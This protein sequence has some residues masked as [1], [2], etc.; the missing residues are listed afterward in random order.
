ML[1]PTLLFVLV[2]ALPLLGFYFYIALR[3]KNKN[4]M[5]G[6]IVIALLFVFAAIIAYYVNRGK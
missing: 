2:F 4:R 6:L 5:L 1:F 3:D